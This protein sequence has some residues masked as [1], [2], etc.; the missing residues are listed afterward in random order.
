[1]I[2]GIDGDKWYACNGLD[3]GN[4]RAQYVFTNTCREAIEAFHKKYCDRLGERDNALDKHRSYLDMTV[5]EYR[6][7]EK[8]IEEEQEEE[9]RENGQFGVGA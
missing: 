4:P 9:R 6:D 5:A 7:A 8:I 2:I 1:M 3:L